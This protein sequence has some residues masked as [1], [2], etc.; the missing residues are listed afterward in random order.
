[1]ENAREAF[2][3]W[4]LDDFSAVPDSLLFRDYSDVFCFCRVNGEGGMLLMGHSE[5]FYGQIFFLN[6]AAF[7]DETTYKLADS[8]GQFLNSLT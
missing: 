4:Y 8:L 1:V 3:F 7:G 6:G 5:K 2:E